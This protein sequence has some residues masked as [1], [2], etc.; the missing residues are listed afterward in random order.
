MSDYIDLGGT[1]V[2][3]Y[4]LMTSKA[5]DL[6]TAIIANTFYNASF[7]ECRKDAETER[8][9][10]IFDVKVD[11]AQVQVVKIL[12]VERIACVFAWQD[13]SIPLIYALR[14]DFPATAHMHLMKTEF[15]RCLCI[16]DEDYDDIKISW[17]TPGMMFRISNWLT[18]TSI[19]EL[20]N[21][22]QPLELLL[23]LANDDLIL[24]ESWDAKILQ[25]EIRESTNGRKTYIPVP[26]NKNSE[27]KMFLAA[28]FQGRPLVHGVMRRMPES[29]FELAQIA[30]EAGINLIYELKQ[31]CLL[32]F[33]LGVKNPKFY[34]MAEF[35]VIL[36]LP[37]CRH[38]GK[39]AETFEWRAFHV[40]DNLLNLGVEL[41]I[42]N[43]YN[44]FPGRNIPEI[45]KDRPGEKI[46]INS[47]NVHM[48]FS[49][50]AASFISGYTDHDE[51]KGI[52]V[53]AGALGSQLLNN[54][55]RTGLGKWTVI[56]GDD[57]APH[58]L[59]R[60]ILKRDDIGKN[61]ALSLASSMNRI[62]NEDGAVEGIA[63]NI[64]S[65]GH[66]EEKIS[67]ALSEAQIILDASTSIAVER[68]LAK[69]IESSARRGSV[70]F[71]PPGTDLVILIEDQGRKSTLDFLEIQ[72]YRGICN[73]PM[74]H[75]HLRTES[76]KIRYATS[77]RDISSRIPLDN[78][79]LLSSICSAYIHQSIDNLEAGINVWTLDPKSITVQRHVFKTFANIDCGKQKDWRIVTDEYLLQSVYSYR[80]QKL[81]NETGGILLGSY[82]MYRKIVYIVDTIPSPPDSKEWP[83]AYIRGN[84][85]L[86]NNVQYVKEITQNK[87]EYVGEWHSHPDGFE[88]TP[89]SDDLKFMQWVKDNMKHD[90][91]PG[92]MLIVEKNK[93]Q[94]ILDY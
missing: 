61:K 21:P 72:Y 54:L 18:K 9:I 19:G 30:E 29:L 3:P 5:K 25:F 88:V 8:D 15:P 81:P 77:C 65:P 24:P 89:S 10:V 51:I 27:E 69:D 56:D 92:L 75:N 22:D 37:K 23:P 68:Y 66:N 58:N 86:Q 73:Q 55:V 4:E 17:S 63:A 16:F 87:L 20:H 91:H 2:S 80:E 82:D 50:K 35:I 52:L 12:D 79:V 41:G 76:G 34:K 70:F 43:V 44:G 39:D 40:K 62:Q 42:W 94:F 26:F 47:L 60:H 33:D 78:V 93:Y 67:K 84:K 59:A 83:Y 74:L 28:A 57:L 53:G 49:R 90:G 13:D 14:S 38:E 46:R 36:D 45:E 48:P 64:L 71:N 7:V 85:G 11:L 1:Q 32:I 31:K 6:A